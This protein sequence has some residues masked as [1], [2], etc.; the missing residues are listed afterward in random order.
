V[1]TGD[2]RRLIDE[3]AEA[4]ASF[5]PVALATVV[6]TKRSVP[7][8]S[9]AK[10]L[11]YA[12]GSSSGTVGGGAMEARVV[13]AA[14]ESLSNGKTQLLTYELLEP[15]RGDPGVCGGEV[16]IYLEPYMPPHTVFV[17]GA[18]HV[19]RTV[20]E[21][22]HWLGYRTVINDDREGLATGDNVP[23]ADVH[24]ECSVEEALEKEPVTADTSVVLVSRDIA[25]DSDA[26]PRL[27][28]TDAQY[29]GVMGSKRRWLTVEKNLADNGVSPEDLASLHVPIGIE[30][31]A[32][33][34]EEVAVSILAEV[35]KSNRAAE[36]P[37][38]VE[39]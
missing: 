33:T 27:L 28:A 9:G 34:L 11:V 29:V 5:T 15:S 16:Q 39:D 30:L 37:N 10:M 36:A 2:D 23:L 3:L 6:G 26:V 24:L 17:I 8:R 35:I 32:E 20:V 31:G 21:L 22:A 25:I 12:D 38:D 13:T 19:G 4:V 14:T 7:R 1:K 18:G